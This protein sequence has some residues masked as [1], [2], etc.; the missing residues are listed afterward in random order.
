MSTVAK[1]APIA[2]VVALGMVTAAHAQSY[3]S[4]HHYRHRPSIEQKSRISASR[5]ELYSYSP[6]NGYDPGY[7]ASDTAAALDE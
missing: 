1:R 7:P 3:P 5:R 4:I 2:A 6:S